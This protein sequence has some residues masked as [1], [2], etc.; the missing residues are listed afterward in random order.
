MDFATLLKF[1]HVFAAVLWVGGG[2]TVIIAGIV[3]GPSLLGR[4]AP[5][6]QGYL[7]PGSDARQPI[8]PGDP[9][10]VMYSGGTTG[11]PKGVVLPHFC[12]VSC[13][14][15]MLE[16]ASLGEEEVFFSSSHLYHALLP[17]A[18]DGRDPGLT[19]ADVVL[20]I[21]GG[22]PDRKSVV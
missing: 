3:L 8:A 5:A 14:Y 18:V 2:F 6:A 12:A 16:V 9:F 13:G 1:A 11:R 22:G 17:C 4:V 21:E 15:R 20:L 7:L 19:E 10:C